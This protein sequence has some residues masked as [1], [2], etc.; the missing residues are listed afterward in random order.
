MTTYY[1]KKEIMAISVDSVYKTVLSIL[2]KEQRGFLPPNQFNQLAKQAQLD[3]L[4]NLFYDYNQAVTLYK[5]KRVAEGYGD[6]IQKIEEQIDSHFATQAI[7]GSTLILGSSGVS[8]IYKIV[9]VY[10]TTQ[11]SHVSQNA[12]HEIEVEKVSKSKASYLNSSPLTKPSNDFPVYY[13]DIAT[14]NTI[15]TLPAGQIEILKYIKVPADPKWGFTYSS[16][17]GGYEFSAS[18]AVD[19][20]LHPSKETD[21]VIKILSQAGVVVKDATVIQVAQGKEVFKEQK[22]SR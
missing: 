6:I 2:N 12:L 15:P 22:Q 17:T 19:F 18:S 3:I 16:S 11:N 13:Q 21:L 20:E 9:G 8:N 4:D 5:S 10:R 1:K 7:T 14:I